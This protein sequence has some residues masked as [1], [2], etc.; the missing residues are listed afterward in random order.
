MGVKVMSLEDGD[1]VPTALLSLWTEKEGERLGQRSRRPCAGR[2]SRAKCWAARLS[3]TEWGLDA[4]GDRTEEATV[5]RYIY[6][7]Y[8]RDGPASGSSPA[9]SMEE[10]MRTRRGGLWSMVTVRDILRNR[11]YL[12]T[13]SRFEC[14]CRPFTLL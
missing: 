1:D 6:R 7:L 11:T 5:V 9:G 14:E 12:G 10:N 8:L 4:G 3:A 13:Y 2:Q